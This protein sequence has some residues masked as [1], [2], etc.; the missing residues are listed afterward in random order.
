M[1]EPKLR[2]AASTIEAEEQSIDPASAV[3]VEPEVDIDAV[4]AKIR[5]AV[6][7]REAEGRTQFIEASA[8]LSDL[9]F[10]KLAESS[11]LSLSE[12]EAAGFLALQPDFS[13]NPDGY[14]QLADLLKYHD[15]KFIWN[16]YVAILKREPDEPGLN[17]YL[18]RLRSGRW[19]KVD[20]L[21]SLRFSP[22][23]RRHNVTIEGLKGRAMF[24]RLYRLP[25]IGYVLELVVDLA[26]LPSLIHSDRAMGNYL[27]GQQE[28][29]AAHLND[30]AGRI[31]DRYDALRRDAIQFSNLTRGDDRR[32][33]PVISGDRISRGGHGLQLLGLA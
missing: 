14:Y 1:Q 31:N 5:E 6:A 15:A 10:A 30:T 3:S 24:R 9:L 22:E 29:T 23:G 25:L 4:K 32:S 16:A 28:R 8:A 7:R 27:I 33:C 17:A 11:D 13:P 26:R 18:E 12:T 20:V 2:N 19:N 21:G